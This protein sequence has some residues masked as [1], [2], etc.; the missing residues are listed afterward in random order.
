MVLTNNKKYTIY[1]GFI[2][3]TIFSLMTC[4]KYLSSVVH[5]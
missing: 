4:L 2:L 5:N 1:F 3:Q